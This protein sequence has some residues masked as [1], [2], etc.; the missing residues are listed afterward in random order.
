M[1]CTYSLVV[2][3]LC[4][5]L[6]APPVAGSA[7]RPAQDTPLNNKLKW[8]TASEVNSF[9]FDV[10]RGIAED[11]PFTRITEDPLLASGTSD[12]PQSYQFVD[13]TI[14]A[15]VIYFYYVEEISSSG[16]REKFTPVFASRA[17]GT[18]PANADAGSDID[19][20]F[21]IDVSDQGVYGVHWE[22][23]VTAGL[24][25]QSFA[26]SGLNL[27]SR[28]EPVAIFVA[29]GGDG[30]FGAG[31]WF[32]FRGT[33]PGRVEDGKEQLDTWLT[34]NVYVLTT[35]SSDGTRMTTTPDSEESL[36]SLPQAERWASLRLEHDELLPRF[37]GSG[38]DDDGTQW[39][40][41]KLTH[42]DKTPFSVMLNLSDLDIQAAGR[43]AALK[44][45]LRGWSTQ[46]RTSSDLAD[47][48]IDIRLNGK[49]VASSEWNGTAMHY[50]DV[51]GLKLSEAGPEVPLTVTVPKRIPEG[52]TDA[53]VDVVMIDSVSVDYPRRATVGG[54]QLHVQVQSAGEAQAVF[55]SVA[56]KVTAYF[57]D[58]RRVARTM[59][60]LP[61]NQQAGQ[62][63]L[64]RLAR[65][66]KVEAG[67][68][69]LI[70]VQHGKLRRP[71][72][73]DLDQPSQLADKDNRADYIVVAPRQLMEAVQPLVDFHREEGLAV[74]VVDID[75]VYDEFS[76]GLPL[77][78][79]LRD[80]LEHAW[81]NWAAPQPR[82]VLLVGDASWDTKHSDAGPE[83]YDDLY[84]VPGRTEFAK[85]PSVPYGA[86][87]K[88]NERNLIPTGVYGGGS[89]HSASDNWLVSFEDD[90]YPNMAVGRFPV[91]TAEEVAGIVG[92]TL[93][94]SKAAPQG[95][96]RERV[97]W[98]T[99]EQTYSQER[100]DRLAASAAERG[101][102]AKKIYPASEEKN[103]AEHQAAIGQAL[104][105]GVL[106]VHFLGH[107]GRFIWRTG[108]PDFR[109][110][111]DLFTLED[112]D[113]LTPN[114]SIP[115]VLSMSCYS[116]PFDHPDADSI[117][118]K[119]LRMPDKG[120]VAV[121]AASWR[122]SP[123][124]NFSAA[125]IDGLTQPGTVGEAI[126][127]A[128]RAVKSRTLVE[129]YN[130]L[131][132]PALRLALPPA[133]SE[134]ARP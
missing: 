119:L 99:N 98:I 38:A 125:L 87:P 31:D 55:G 121:L 84:Y 44:L 32:E 80:F 68:T 50:V 82:F 77:A 74:Q 111:H 58:G 92:K 123:A 17:K 79:G 29:D 120:A 48:H 96:W 128:K 13:D 117:G 94:Y 88:A 49:V 100:T 15:G 60:P 90:F 91:T 19:A 122:N 8:T 45:A 4:F 36:V 35:N 103:N 107:G 73:I 5:I 72:S 105:E 130:L 22:D 127:A 30:Q 46:R 34:E 78:A 28:G 27:S 24:P 65:R 113:K 42:V 76:H 9:G 115:L 40:W 83:R 56:S 109:K 93:S 97:L 54:P 57:A 101:F 133:S 112:L 114:Q 129:Q 51:E 11:G 12:E 10:Y 20:R 69:D 21:R 85:I 53:L 124:E 89:G 134:D 102:E 110:N 7:D 116:A 47:H 75:D 64:A 126:V 26:S 71:Q 23:L 106:M 104:D 2:A 43:P 66:F 108:P 25:S 14:D 131:G 95:D 132:D 16:N 37:S 33:G 67:S 1:R 18:A 63:G 39:F 81:R 61:A 118:E 59:P 41:A 70:L 6:V 62:G 86:G 52:E 3:F